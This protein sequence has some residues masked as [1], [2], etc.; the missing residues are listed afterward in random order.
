MQGSREDP[1]IALGD[2]YRGGGLASDRMTLGQRRFV[3]FCGMRLA[4]EIG[5]QM[6]LVGVGWLIYSLSGSVLDLG[7]IGLALFLPAFGLAPF[8]GHAADRHDRRHIL[9]MCYLVELLCAAGLLVLALTATANA[10]RML[11]ALAVFGAARAFE[12]PA[13]N[14]LLPNLVP[15]SLLARAI[16]WNST[17]SQ[18]ARILGPALGGL[19]FAAVPAAVFAGTATLLALA[20]A[21]AG[22]IPATR[23]AAARRGTSWAALLAG[24][25]YIRANR[26]IL[27][28]I[29]LDL[30]ATLLGG[31]IVLLPVFARDILMVGPAGLGLLRGTPAAG[32][33]AMS[34]VLAYRPVR[35]RAG[36]TLLGAVA[37][38]GGA[39]VV[40]GLSIDL[41]LTLVALAVLGAANTL[42]AVIR[43]TLVQ[44]STPDAIRGRITAVHAICTGSADQ[45]DA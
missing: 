20:A 30:F 15:T 27:A 29:S 17:V 12:A 21:F 36:W 38:F 26:R 9:A 40:F 25:V 39:T 2:A 37:C 3:L 16:A 22:T 10:P 42:G 14:A 11:A 43:H 28:A 23:T 18:S 44:I 19:I 45:L 6:Q 4:A 1:P 32:A 34:L 35:G 7:L 5:A 8:T 31:A 13:A 33:L 24:I 41:L